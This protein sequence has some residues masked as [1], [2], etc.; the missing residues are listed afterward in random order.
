[1]KHTIDG[2][3]GAIGHI[4]GVVHRRNRPGHRQSA[5]YRG[6]KRYHFM[7]SQVIVDHSGVIRDIQTGFPGHQQDQTNWNACYIKQHIDNFL[8]AQEYLLGDGIYFGP[9]FI[10]PFS[11]LELARNPI[12]GKWS[13]IQRNRR[14]VVE[15]TN[16]YLERFHALV[17]RFRHSI[18]LQTQTILAAAL[19][20][21]RQLKKR[22]FRRI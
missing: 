20:S 5:Y 19:L 6:D 1:M 22:P 12:Y 17:I 9:H 3:P 14:Q 7:S 2:F 11:N 4:D 18:P 16:G 8:D 13:K 21:N 10:T 15:W